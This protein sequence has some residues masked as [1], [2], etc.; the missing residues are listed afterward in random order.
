MKNTSI[1]TLSSQQDRI[2][3]ELCRAARLLSTFPSDHATDPT[4]V[5]LTTKP[6]DPKQAR[7]ALTMRMCAWPVARS[8]FVLVRVVRRAHLSAILN[9]FASNGGS[10]LATSD[11]R[12]RARCSLCER[13]ERADKFVGLQ[14]TVIASRAPHLL[15]DSKNRGRASPV[16][17]SRT[18]WISTARALTH[19][20]LRDPLHTSTCERGALSECPAARARASHWFDKFL[21]G[22][23]RLSR[24]KQIHTFLNTD[25]NLDLI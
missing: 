11:H 18:S 22:S 4:D 12:Q 1:H 17:S 8:I 19:Y 14:P 24:R 23:A 2:S 9:R 15:L 20:Q 10:G 16:N 3:L 25:L 13:S 6:G 21:L 5:V 7:T